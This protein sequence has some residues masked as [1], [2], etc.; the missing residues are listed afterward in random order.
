[1]CCAECIAIGYKLK[2]NELAATATV[3]LYDHP[4]LGKV[5][6]HSRI[7]E[8]MKHGLARISIGGLIMFRTKQREKRSG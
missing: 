8:E 7:V 3:A 2:I 1:M 5:V 4:A 6:L